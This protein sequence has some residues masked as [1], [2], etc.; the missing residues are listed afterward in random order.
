[1]H[2]NQ[3]SLNL[4]PAWYEHILSEIIWTYSQWFEHILSEVYTKWNGVII[5]AGELNI[6][7]LN[8]SKESQRR[9]K[10]I[11]HS[12]PLR[13]QITSLTRKSKTLIDHV[14]NT[15][16]DR[17]IHRDVLNTEEISDHDTPYITFNIKK[18]K[19]EPRYK[20]IRNKKSLV[21][22]NYVT[23]FQQLPLNLVYSFDDPD[24]QVAM[25]NKL[26]TDCINIHAPLKRVNL[27]RPIA[28]WMH[29]PK[30][31]E[32][33]KELALQRETYRNHE[34]S[35]NHENYQNTRN[36]LKKVIKKN[37]NQFSS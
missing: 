35:I 22:E 6:N 11:L 15:I 1:M 7:L 24:D 3:Q 10:N 27:T 12:F 2:Y 4:F 23:D 17:V 25:L 31:I 29:D 13:Q 8:G 21:M 32:L 19:Y 30:I 33:Q 28:P 14:I 26:I 9:Y 16:P 34:T 36:K 37:K 20:F 5:L 18:E